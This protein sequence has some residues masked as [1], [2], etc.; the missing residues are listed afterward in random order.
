MNLPCNPNIQKKNRKGNTKEVER[1][2]YQRKTYNLMKR[3]TQYEE[4]TKPKIEKLIIH[5]NPWLDYLRNKQKTQ[6]KKDICGAT[7]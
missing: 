1:K 7:W 3:K 5:K 6:H 2:E 4:S